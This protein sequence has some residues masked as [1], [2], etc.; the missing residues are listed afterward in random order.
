MSVNILG[1]I[2]GATSGVVVF[3]PVTI[4][5][6]EAEFD[7][8]LA[9]KFA[10]N[11]VVSNIASNGNYSTSLPVSDRGDVPTYYVAIF[12]DNTRHLFAVS[13]STPNNT[14]LSDLLTTEASSSPGGTAS[15]VT[16]SNQISGYALEAGGNLEAVKSAILL[17]AKLSETQPVKGLG[18]VLRGS[19]TRPN[20]TNG[21]GANSVQGGVFSLATNYPPGTVILPI[22]IE[23]ISTNTI[24]LGAKSVFFLNSDLTT[25]IPD[26]GTWNPSEADMRA[27]CSSL[28]GIP[29]GNMAQPFT[30]ASYAVA[31]YQGTQNQIT[32]GADGSVKAYVISASAYT[33]IA[34]SVMSLKVGTVAV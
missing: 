25:T 3:V 22:D 16:V 32:V 34:L 33:P 4:P 27:K 5:S 24:D 21:Y 31:A 19:F 15:T 1:N 2:A 26:G 14:N 28:A 7:T 8:D 13:G 17:Q 20:N 18:Q 10:P 6:N 23:F 11:R 29:L 9:N 30:G 12:P